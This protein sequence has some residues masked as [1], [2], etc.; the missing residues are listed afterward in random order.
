MPTSPPRRVSRLDLV[1]TTTTTAT[2]NRPLRH[3]RGPPGPV[4]SSVA[5]HEI[6]ALIKSHRAYHNSSGS[7]IFLSEREKHGLVACDQR[8][9]PWVRHMCRTGVHGMYA[10]GLSAAGN[11]QLNGKSPDFC[12]M[13]DSNYDL[14]YTR[15]TIAK[16]MRFDAKTPHADW[17]VGFSAGRRRTR[18]PC[19]R[20]GS[21]TTARHSR[22]H[23]HRGQKSRQNGCKAPRST[24]DRITT[25]SSR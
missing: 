20:F 22:S 25:P 16:T 21:R 10:L 4:F 13:Q 7:L 19:S 23:R 1:P 8:D 5:R 17:I 9:L 6:D 2:T 3:L 11:A 18:A 15:L 12:A 14:S 24:S